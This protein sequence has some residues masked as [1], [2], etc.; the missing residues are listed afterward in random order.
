MHA[1][2]LSINLYLNAGLRQIYDENESYILDLIKPKSDGMTRKI[3]N[4]YRFAM[5]Q[6]KDRKLSLPAG[7]THFT[8]FMPKRSCVKPLPQ[9]IIGDAIIEEEFLN[10]TEFFDVMPT[11][12]K[13]RITK[14]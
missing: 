3:R 8:C 5:M 13:S 4:P 11:N 6:K 2:N 7:H 10:D 9:H 12:S 14:G 1:A